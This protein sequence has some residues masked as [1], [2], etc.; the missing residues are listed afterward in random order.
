MK[1]GRTLPPAAAP[2][3]CADIWHG[4]AGMLFPGRAI[5]AL[6]DEI[7][8][9]FGVRHVFLVSSG[10]AA[11]TVTLMALKSLRPQ[12]EVV[13]PAYTCYSVPAAILKAGLTPALCDIDP[14]TFD[15]DHALLQEVLNENTLCVLAHHLFGI[16]ADI[17]RIRTVSASHRPFVVEDAAQAMGAES[18][19]N[20]L[21]TLG[22][23]G[24]FSL[25][26]GKNITCGSGGIIVTNSDDI[27]GAIT[28]EY[29]TLERARPAEVLKDV[30]ALLLMAI[31]IRPS[32]YWIP[33]ALPFLRLGQ[34]LFP[35]KV[36]LTRLSGLKAGVL[37]NWRRRLARSNGIRS[38]TAAYFCRRLHLELPPGP[39]HPYLRLPVLAATPQEKRRLHALSEARGLGLS[40]AYPAPVSE[41]PQ[42][43]AVVN[44]HRFPHAAQVADSLVTIPT[45][46]WLS[47]KDKRAIADVWEMAHAS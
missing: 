3:Y 15:F 35:T 10:T 39:S 18:H 37:H 32:L 1:I 2:L 30:L 26:R 45:H 31:F 20:R 19:G 47:E 46:H 23:V 41:I 16:P 42:L 8:R 12:T 22:D 40:V 4:V 7:R 24:I 43:R 38:E 25:G 14:A 36:P 13:M 34:T 27:A 5:R 6:E 11:L 44:G 21:G 29:R 9:D 28:R 17:E 33:A